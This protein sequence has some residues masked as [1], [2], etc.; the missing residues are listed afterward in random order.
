MG[1]IHQVVTTDALDDAVDQLLKHL[2]QAGPQAVQACKKL[3]LDVAERDI[4]ATLIRDTVERIADIRASNEGKE[5]VQAFLG[6]RKPNW[7]S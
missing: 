7:L 5:G 1:F 6:K 4:N 3:V 2:L